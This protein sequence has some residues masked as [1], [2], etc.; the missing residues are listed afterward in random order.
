M[1]TQT[2]K[3][4]Y[5]GKQWTKAREKAQAIANKTGATFYAFPEHDGSIAIEIDYPKSG[6]EFE[7]FKPKAVTDSTSTVAGERKPV[8]DETAGART[9]LVYPD[10]C[11]KC[12]RQW[13]DHTTDR[14]LISRG[15]CPFVA[16]PGEIQSPTLVQKGGKYVL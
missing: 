15:A 14:E 9:R 6:V 13:G 8:R 4:E 1:K 12:G 11:A 5:K 10:Q 2:D 7:I 16:K 3:A